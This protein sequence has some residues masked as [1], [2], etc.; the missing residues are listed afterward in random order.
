LSKEIQFCFSIKG[1]IAP[2]EAIIFDNILIR[3]IPPSDGA[4][5]YFKAIKKE[6]PDEEKTKEED[7]LINSLRGTIGSIVQIYALLSGHHVTVLPGHSSTYISA[8]RPF[9]YEKLRGNLTLIPVFDEIRR[10]KEMPI[11]KKTMAK[12]EEIKNIF[13]KKKK[14]FL[15]NAIDYYN[16]SLGD[17]SYEEKLI[18]LMISLESLLSREQD[19]LR[20]RYSLR[21]AYL[22]GVGQEEKRPE[23]FENIQNLYVKRSKVVHGNEAVNLTYQE[24]TT[25]QENVAEVIKRLVYIEKS[26]DEFLKLLDE[27]VYDKKK[28]EELNQI[29]TE[30]IKKW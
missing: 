30:A 27:S 6:V 2:Q 3:G 18:D 8:E 24:M 17:A 23:I 14:R 19:E 1:L 13:I 26:K 21:A 10:K 25:L 12:Y 29:V 4:C 20:L 9:G 5:I 22:L 28:L 15:K 16:R 7:N 11:L